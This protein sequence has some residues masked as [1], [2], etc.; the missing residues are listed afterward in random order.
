MR[1][2]RQDNCTDVIIEDLKATPNPGLHYH[3][4]QASKHNLC[5]SKRHGQSNGNVL[6]SSELRDEG[7]C[8]HL[9]RTRDKGAIGGSVN[10]VSK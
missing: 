5:R 3:K 8:R 10:L 7:I 4:E 6:I 9:D 2:H 1:Q